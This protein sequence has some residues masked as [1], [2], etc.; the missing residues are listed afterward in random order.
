MEADRKAYDYLIKFIIVGDSGTGKTCLLLR[1]TDERF[2]P[3]HDLTIG[4]EFGTKT[5]S[6]QQTSLKLQIWDTVI[7]RQ[8][9][10]E[11]YRSITRSYY[12]GAAVAL[13]V[14]DLTSQL[15]F[16]HIGQWVREV[17]QNS[18][19]ATIV[20]LIGNKTDLAHQ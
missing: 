8:A 2:K 12:R 10:Q 17:R 6:L 4:V 18:N 16:T 19:D 14:F 7:A 9:G 5:L 1:F 11:S 3:D 13:L 15:S 20:V